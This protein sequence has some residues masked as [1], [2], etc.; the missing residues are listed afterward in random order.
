MVLK[1]GEMSPVKSVMGSVATQEKTF[2]RLSFWPAKRLLYI[3]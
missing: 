1:R 2:W 3:R